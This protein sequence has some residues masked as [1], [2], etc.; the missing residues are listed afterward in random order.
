MFSSDKCCNQAQKLHPPGT[1]LDVISSNDNCTMVSIC[2]PILSS[3][4]IKNIITQ[5]KLICEEGP[6]ITAKIE[7][8]CVTEG[9]EDIRDIKKDIKKIMK[10]IE[11]NK[12]CTISNSNSTNSGNNNTENMEPKGVFT[13]QT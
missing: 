8:D 4:F 1:V 7:H 3:S 2:I 13:H 12:I 6:R 9:F 5:V 10:E 11:E